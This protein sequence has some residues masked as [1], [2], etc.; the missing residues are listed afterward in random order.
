MTKRTRREGREID[1]SIRRGET[2][3]TRRVG[4]H[5]DESHPAQG[6][7]KRRNEPDAQL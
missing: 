7:S 4:R 6:V 5:I 1:K 3:R 2:K